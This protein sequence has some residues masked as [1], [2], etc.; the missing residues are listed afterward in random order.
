MHQFFYESSPKPTRH[1][2]GTANVWAVEGVA[3]YF[4]S[5]VERTVEPAV[6]GRC[7]TIGTAEAGRLQAARHRRIV[8][9]FSVPLAELSALGMTDL[10]QR[11]DVAKLYSQSAGL[12]TFFMDYE[13]GKYR[14]AFRKLLEAVYAGR[15]EADTLAKLTGESYE[16]LDAQYRE[17]M[18][19]LPVTAAVAPEANP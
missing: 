12:A 6:A 18:E 4:E 9:D 15:D 2:A 14:P 1:L 8:D 11:P 7:Y 13:N 10:Q 3:C 19:S 17:F 5:L 16:H